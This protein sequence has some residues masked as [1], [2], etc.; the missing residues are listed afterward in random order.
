MG[1]TKDNAISNSRL[2]LPHLRS[3]ATQ[4]GNTSDKENQGHTKGTRTPASTTKSLGKE[5]P[6][7]KPH[8]K[9]STPAK[10]LGNAIEIGAYET[11]KRALTKKPVDESSDN[12]SK[13]SEDERIS[14]HSKA[15]SRSAGES[16]DEDDATEESTKGDGDESEIDAD[17]TVRTMLFMFL[18]QYS[19]QIGLSQPRVGLPRS[20]SRGGETPDEKEA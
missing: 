1:K 3:K 9:K 6:K 10:S 8:S 14:L 12:E 15:I 4:G 19:I 18:R 2:K 5:K 7:L 17:K 13:T 20:R 11:E 16:D